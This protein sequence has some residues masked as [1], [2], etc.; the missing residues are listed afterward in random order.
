LKAFLVL[1]V[2]GTL[3]LLAYG[4]WTRRA[5]MPVESPPRTIAVLPFKPLVDTARDEPLEMGICNALIVRLGGL[6]QLTVRPTSS[7]VSYNKLGQDP[8][9]A[10]RELGVDALLLGYIQRSGDRIRVTAQ[11][12]RTADGKP[13]WSGQFNEK[14]TDIFAVEDSISRQMAEALRLNLTGDEQR[15]VARHFTENVE[16]YESYMKGIYFQDKRTPE[17][18]RKSIQ[19]FQQ[20]T[21]RD[22]Q[23]AL[24]F[25]G[26][27]EAYALHAVRADMPAHESYRQA[28]S[29]AMRALEIDETSVEAHMVLAH[30]R[31]WYDWDWS[32][33]ESEFKRAG[34]LGRNHPRAAQYYASYLIIMGRH[35][36]AVSEIKRARRLAPLSLNINVQVARMLF[37]A[38]EYDE[39][40]EQCRKTLEMDPDYGG[41]HLFLGKI[42]KQKGLYREAL[43]ELERAR[44]L[45][46]D[47]AEILSMIGY[48]HAAAGRRTEAEQVLQELDGLSRQ[49]YI[50]P[51]HAA[52]IYAGLGEKDKAFGRLEQA[53]QEREGR[54]TL[55]KSAPEFDGLRSD[56]RL[57]TLLQRMNLL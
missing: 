25:A 13:L 41:A 51:Y 2:A 18:L 22:P 45:L 7:V 3:G 9:A 21:E 20:A 17:G 34:E 53:Y 50:S 15:Q 56:P 38:R 33:A 16:A 32:G 31:C 14:F 54:M 47:N 1:L 24:A 10:G 39:A 36:E 6:S 35:Q 27:A 19:Y 29:A 8:L 55:L 11:L 42:Y 23:Y 28:K 52:V 43:A 48:T 49:R 44:E 12:L 40:I 4:M 26:L 37:F 5:V 46:G 57:T 30:I